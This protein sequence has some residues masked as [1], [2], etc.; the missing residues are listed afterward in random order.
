M[1]ERLGEVGQGLKDIGDAVKLIKQIQ[2]KES[3]LIEFTEEIKNQASKLVKISLPDHPRL[4]RLEPQLQH[5][6]ENFIFLINS[7]GD[8]EN[9]LE[10]FFKK[11][12][13]CN[14]FI[15]SQIQNGSIPPEATKEIYKALMYLNNMVNDFFKYFE[16][17]ITNLNESQHIAEELKC[18]LEETAKEIEEEATE[19]EQAEL[20]RQAEIKQQT[21]MGRQAEVKQKRWTIG[22][23]L[24]LLVGG[25]S[26]AALGFF[27]GGAA[28][29]AAG[30]IVGAVGYSYYPSNDSNDSQV[31][32]DSRSI[33]SDLGAMR[34]L[35]ENIK[36]TS[37]QL[38]VI[39][40][41]LKYSCNEASK[42]HLS[43]TDKEALQT[44]LEFLQKDQA[45][46]DRINQQQAEINELKAKMRRH[47]IE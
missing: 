32:A 44:A 39:A 26:L 46:D 35:A 4:K 24:G 7:E 22:S 19:A 15:N 43:E 47:G 34:H 42:I 21:E 33:Q 5:L 40:T 25:A 3:L 18:Q 13:R 2:K 28:F 17:F 38:G 1:V 6:R 30:A 8:L 14:E 41:R 23:T 37:N 16:K 20:K 9:W 11:L 31:G 29:A 27:T 10:A 12:T 45:K 36:A